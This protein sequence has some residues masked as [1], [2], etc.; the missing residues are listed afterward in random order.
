M[1][2]HYLDLGLLILRVVVGLTIAAHGY[3]KFFGGGRIPGTA[4]WFDG[5]GM[6]PGR[7]HA[8]LAASTELGAGILFAAGALTSLA[9]MAFVALMFVAAYTVHKS[10]FVTKNGWEYN[11]VL[12]TVG[13]SVATIGPGRWSVDHLIGIDT[14]FDGAWGLAISVVGGLVAATLLLAVFFRPPV[15]DDAA[16]PRNDSPRHGVT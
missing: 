2:Q 1:S 13:V 5:I 8:V 11:L 3:N 6:R 7:M 4:G 16:A 14:W 10:F 12:A 15:R 9:S